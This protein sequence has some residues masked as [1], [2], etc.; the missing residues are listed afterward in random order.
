VTFVCRAACSAIEGPPEVGVPY[1]KRA[2]T[3]G[4]SSKKLAP[5]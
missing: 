2:R 1:E 3:E 5:H 4:P